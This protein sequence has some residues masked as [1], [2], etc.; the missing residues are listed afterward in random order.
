MKTV[1]EE[2]TATLREK[3]S[4][5]IGFLFP[6]SNVGAFEEKLN[7]VKSDYPD[8]THHCYA[9]RIEPGNLKEIARD[10]REPGGTAGIPIL[11]KLRA[12]EIVNAGLIVVRYYGGTDLG[13]SGLIDAYGKTAEW[14]VR[15]ASLQSVVRTLNVEVRY[16]Y[17]RQKQI[18]RLKSLY[19]LEERD[20]EYLEEVRLVLACPLEQAVTLFR[21]LEHL[22]HLNIRHKKLK[23]SFVIK[24]STD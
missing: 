5:F 11:N 19:N 15:N 23:E 2:T 12:G 22:G 17:H 20:A 3:G 7:T 14:C 10:D 16:P 24:D 9:Y 1:E 18:D 4:R 6:V 13:K 8:A 21:E